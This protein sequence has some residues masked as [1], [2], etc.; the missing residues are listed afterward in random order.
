MNVSK[1]AREAV[2][3]AEIAPQANAAIANLNCRA[4]SSGKRMSANAAP[5]THN[6]PNTSELLDN[7]SARIPSTET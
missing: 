4:V 6:V 1:T 5:P 3:I 7:V 2:S